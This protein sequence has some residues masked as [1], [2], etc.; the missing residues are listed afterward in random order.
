MELY[1]IYVIP[2][3][4]CLILIQVEKKLTYICKKGLCMFCKVEATIPFPTNDLKQHYTK[5]EYIR[6]HREYSCHCI[7]WS[8]VS[9]LWIPTLILF[10]I[11]KANKN[12]N[13]R[14]SGL[15]CSYN[16]F[17]V[18]Y[19]LVFAKDSRHSKIRYFG[20]HVMV[21]QHITRLQVP[22]NDFKSG[23]LMKI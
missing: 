21:Q 17:G 5:A 2:F 6:L 16:S 12:R 1:F 7:F 13:K 22:V 3:S 23:V 14:R 11:K 20:N 19:I 10:F 18:S 4:F 9:T 15:L 8:H